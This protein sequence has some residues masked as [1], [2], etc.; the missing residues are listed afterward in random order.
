MLKQ[1]YKIYLLL[2]KYGEESAHDFLVK[3]RKQDRLRE[4]MREKMPIKIFYGAYG[5]SWAEK[6]I[7]PFEMTEEEKE[8]Y[9]EEN[10]LHIYSMYDCTGETFTQD[11]KCFSVNGKTIVY[12]FKAIDC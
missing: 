5:D 9:I 6:I 11:I 7:L 2:K 4:A 10:W 3:H 8:E 12:H 1:D